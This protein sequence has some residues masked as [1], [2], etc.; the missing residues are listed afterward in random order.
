MSL[1]MV[2]IFSAL[3]FAK[4]SPNLNLSG[5]VFTDR[6]RAIDHEIHDNLLDLGG[7]GFDRREVRREIQFQLDGLGDRRPDELRNLSNQLSQIHRLGDETPL[8]R[9]GQHLAGE[10][11][12]A[13]TGLYDS[14]QMRPHRVIHRNLRIR[15]ARKPKNACQQVV[16][17]MRDA[18][19]QQ[20]QALQLLSFLQ[21]ALEL[22]SFA[23]I[24]YVELN[25]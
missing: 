14:P 16:E 3:D 22:L 25:R 7:I 8:A 10:K 5:R 13:F 18:S 12:G 4:R 19:C 9:V 15:K 6:F 23:D 11:G 17:I 1:S 2:P 21:L 20:S 24:P